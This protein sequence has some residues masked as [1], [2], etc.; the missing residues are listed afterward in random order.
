M[1]HRLEHDARPVPFVLIKFE[2]FHTVK[3]LFEPVH[4]DSTG[5]ADMALARLTEGVPGSDKD[6]R[7]IQQDAAEIRRAEPGPFDAGK[8]IEGAPWRHKAQIGESGDTPGGI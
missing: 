7:L 2:P 8:E 1:T 6:V 4:A 5:N 3:G